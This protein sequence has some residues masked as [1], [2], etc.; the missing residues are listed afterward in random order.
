ML[1]KKGGGELYN[2]M[3]IKDG[4]FKTTLKKQIKM[5]DDGKILTIGLDLAPIQFIQQVE[6]SYF[7]V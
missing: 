7:Q 4:Q 3:L 6:L 1:S 2:K 5:E